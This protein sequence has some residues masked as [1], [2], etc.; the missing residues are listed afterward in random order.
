[1]ILMAIRSHPERAYAGGVHEVV[2]EMTKNKVLLTSNTVSSVFMTLI[3][4]GL[5]E[6][7][8][9]PEY[10]KLGRE[11]R[12]SPRKYFKMTEAGE[13]EIEE[14]AKIIDMLREREWK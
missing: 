12:G 3:V 11:R 9:P 2:R 4:R 7:S 14:I 1:M 13:A 8:H 10:Q 6:R 5:I